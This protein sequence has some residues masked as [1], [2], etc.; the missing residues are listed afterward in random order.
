MHLNRLVDI[1]YRNIDPL[2]VGLSTPIAIASSNVEIERLKRYA[3]LEDL[4]E[5]GY[6]ESSFDSDD[7]AKNSK[8]TNKKTGAAIENSDR[9][10]F[11]SWKTY[12]SL[13]REK[14]TRGFFMAGGVISMSSIAIGFGRSVG[15][16]MNNVDIGNIEQ[17]TNSAEH[18]AYLAAIAIGTNLL[19]AGYEGVKSLY[20][21]FII[22]VILFSKLINLAYL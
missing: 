4:R 13:D 16:M 8:F 5:K 20:K 15:T 12:R 6:L 7:F 17:A 2:L 19:S 22:N 14:E 18:L 9:S 11:Y 21:K 3:T 1:A 10:I